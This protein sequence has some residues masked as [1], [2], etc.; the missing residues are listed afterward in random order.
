MTEGFIHVPKTH[1][2][3]NN[4]HFYGGVTYGYRHSDNSIVIAKALCSDKDIY[5]KGIG[6]KITRQLMD[7]TLDEEAGVVPGWSEVITLAQVK[8]VFLEDDDKSISHVFPL[9]TASGAR[10][11]INNIKSFNDINRLFI[12]IICKF[13]LTGKGEYM[14]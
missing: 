8:E 6:R 10:D 12:H 9:L 11:A 14:K 4:E 1:S 13:Y 3:K 5:S 7:E 2:I